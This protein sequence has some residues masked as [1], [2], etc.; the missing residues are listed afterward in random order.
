M[1]NK[2]T[3]DLGTCLLLLSTQVLHQGLRKFI[4][5]LSPTNLLNLNFDIDEEHHFPLVWSTA[6]FLFAIWNFRVEK[7]RVELFK[8]RAEM[9][10]RLLRESR[11][12]ATSNRLSQIFDNTEM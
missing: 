7:K 4:P 8:I 10:C 6:V 1:S 2:Y 9:E 3:R 11:L 12:T 5:N